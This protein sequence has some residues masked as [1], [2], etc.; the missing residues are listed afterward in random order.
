MYALM[1][2]GASRGTYD[3]LLRDCGI[4]GNDLTHCI[5]RDSNFYDIVINQYIKIILE[6]VGFKNNVA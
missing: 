2:S 5:I 1:K 6:Y 4:C 3:K